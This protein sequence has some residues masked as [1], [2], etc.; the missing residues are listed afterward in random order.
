M[1]PPDNRI[2]QL[3][4]P[5]CVVVW[6]KFCKYFSSFSSRYDRILLFPALALFNTLAKLLIPFL[7]LKKCP[8]KLRG[9]FL[10]FFTDQFRNV[11]FQFAKCERGCVT[12][13]VK[14]PLLIEQSHK[15]SSLN[16]NFYFYQDFFL[17]IFLLL[18]NFSK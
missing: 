18:K 12:A 2:C 7:N 10:I 11:S 16:Y 3:I 9:P 6:L 1:M 17:P 13:I 14:L 4:S 5:H 15:R 8:L